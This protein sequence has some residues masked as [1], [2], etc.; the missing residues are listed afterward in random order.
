[1]AVSPVLRLHLPIP[2]SAWP[3]HKCHAFTLTELLVVIAVIA[4]LAGCCC[5]RWPP[6][7]EKPDHRLL[8]QPAANFTGFQA[9][10]G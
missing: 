9:F 5:P 4:I 10:E 3:K 6:P 7:R 2:Q 1:M 8:E